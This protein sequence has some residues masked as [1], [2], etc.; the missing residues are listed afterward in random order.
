MIS[1]SAMYQ[2]QHRVRFS[3]LLQQMGRGLGM[4]PPK[5]TCVW[6]KGPFGLLEN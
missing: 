6:V 4:F 5:I 1:D 2:I 3:I